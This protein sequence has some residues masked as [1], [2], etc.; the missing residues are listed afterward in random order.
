[1]GSL[2]TRSQRMPRHRFGL[3]SRRGRRLLSKKAHA[4]AHGFTGDLASFPC[5]RLNAPLPRRSLPL[6]TR[7][8]SNKAHLQP[9]QSCIAMANRKRSTGGAGRQQLAKPRQ[10]QV[11]KSL[12]N[13]P[14]L[15]VIETVGQVYWCLMDISWC[16]KQDFLALLSAALAVTFEVWRQYLKWPSSSRA[17]RGLDVGSSL[18][19]LGNIIWLFGEALFDPSL[20]EAERWWVSQELPMVKA[21]AATYADWVLAAQGTLLIAFSVIVASAS[22]QA[23]ALRIART[24]PKKVSTGFRLGRLRPSPKVASSVS[25]PPLTKSLY[26]QV[27][28]GSWILKD[29]CWT[30]ELPFYALFFSGMVFSAKFQLGGRTRIA[31]SRFYWIVGNSLWMSDELLASDQSALIRGGGTLLLLSAASLCALEL[32]NTTGKTPS[33]ASTGTST[34]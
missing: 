30:A 1:M 14:A 8:D 11:G 3:C 12:L 19:L 20:E 31:M 16:C 13:L 28:I 2:E 25:R 7:I 6:L 10:K 17:E 34:R 22:L 32:F 23:R 18:W 29:I 33:V 21:D 9:R 4:Q 27:V 5:M 26:E 15:D 24:Q